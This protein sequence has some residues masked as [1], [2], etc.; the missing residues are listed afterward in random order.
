LMLVGVEPDL[1]CADGRAALEAMKTAEFVLAFTPFLGESLERYADIVL[2]MGTFAE[3]SGTFVNA[4]GAWQSF[5]GVADTVGQA[6]P[7]WKILRVLGNLVELPDCEYDS[8]EEVRDELRNLVGD[9]KPDNRVPLDQAP[10]DGVEQRGAEGLDVPMYGIDAL[11]RRS[12]P[13][14][15][16]REGKESFIEATEK[17]KSA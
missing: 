5:G 14:Q 3:T 10:I 9:P 15:E 6:R 4:A 7:G 2:P 12:G 8:S 13:L 17:R 16:T 1:D 11:V